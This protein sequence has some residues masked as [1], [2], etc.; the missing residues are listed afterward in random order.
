[1]EL[2]GEEGGHGR[3]SG[4]RRGGEEGVVEPDKPGLRVL[5]KARIFWRAI[6]AFGSTLRPGLGVGTGRGIGQK[7][8]CASIYLAGLVPVL[9]V[10]AW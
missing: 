1:M 4:V 9:G 8:Q 10:L 2:D 5:S 6:R 7:K 3:T